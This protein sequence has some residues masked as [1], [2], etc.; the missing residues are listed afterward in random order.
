MDI[1]VL[2]D[3]LTHEPLGFGQGE[4]VIHQGFHFGVTTVTEKLIIF[5]VMNVIKNHGLNYF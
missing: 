5:D 4:F 2:L 3:E 1:N